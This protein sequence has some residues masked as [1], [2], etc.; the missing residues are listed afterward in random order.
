ML[1]A[2]LV[3]LLAAGGNSTF[4]QNDKGATIQVGFDDASQWYL[5][6]VFAEAVAAIVLAFLFLYWVFKKYGRH[7]V[8]D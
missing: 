4:I 3:A 6:V 2:L 7:F 8:Y 5:N 1:S